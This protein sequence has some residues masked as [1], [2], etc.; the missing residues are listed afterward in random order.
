MAHAGYLNPPAPMM[1]TDPMFV[2]NLRPVVSLV[3]LS[4]ANRFVITRKLKTLRQMPNPENIASDIIVVVVLIVKVIQC[5]YSYYP[6]PE[7][8]AFIGGA[9]RGRYE[10]D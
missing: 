3:W 4:L 8:V 2:H 10:F 5:V 7:P 1:I 9:S 6:Q